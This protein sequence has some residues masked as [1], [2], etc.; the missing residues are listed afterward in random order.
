MGTALFG[1]VSGPDIKAAEHLLEKA[2]PFIDGIELRLDYF[3]KINLPTLKAF[4]AKCG[5]PVMFTVRRKDQGGFFR[6]AEKERL[7]LLESL[8]ELHPAYVDL[9]YDVPVD[10]RKRLFETYPKI[11]F[12]SSYHDFSQT[13]EDLDALYEKIRTPYA[14][15]YKLVVTARSSID[16]LR[17]LSFVRSRSDREKLIG[18]SMGEE[19]QITRLLAPVVGCVLTYAAQSGIG[20]TTAP[21]QLSAR[22]MQEIY[23]FRKLNR[24]TSIYGLIGDP[25]DKSLGALVHNAVFERQN[26]NAVYL[27]I[28]VTTE[29]LSAFFALMHKL[30]FKGLSVTMPHKESVMTFLT[31][32]SPQARAIGACNTM[33]KMAEGKWAGYNTDGIGALNAIEK[34]ESV[35]G[36]HVIFIG[37]G[38]AAKALVFEAA[39]RGAH[40]TVIN[41]TPA[42]AIEIAHAVKGQGGDGTLSLRSVKRAMT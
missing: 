12:L 42:K 15:I 33:V 39:Q 28:R 36:K 14:H 11:L 21:G 40:V 30:P 10:F 16:A 18:I 2:R 13:P 17:M 27:K 7:A 6:G 41:R 31:E 9:E 3:H 22:E 34:R 25:V 19:G 29:Q 26:I 32:I 5:L 20:D 38:G 4:V 1:V 37:A 8:C 35:L 24:Q 23:R